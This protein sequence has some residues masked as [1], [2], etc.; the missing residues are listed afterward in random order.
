VNLEQVAVIHGGADD[1]LHVVRLAALLRHQPVELR[2]FSIRDV[3]AGLEGRIL[4]VVERQEA[5]QLA[6]LGDARAVVG[7]GE[8]RDPALRRV[9]ARAAE[10]LLGDLFVR[11]RPDHVRA[12]DEHVA[13]LLHHEDEVGD[14]RRVHR[15]TGA[16][17]H[18]AAD[19]R[20]HAA[21]Q[22]V[23]QEDVRVA[24]QRFDAF[25]DA[26]AARVVQA[27][28]RCAHL[29]RQVHDLADLGSVGRAQRS[30]EHREVLSEDED[31]PPVHGAVAR[32]D[33]VAEHL[34]LLHAEVG[35][36]MGDEAIDLDEAARVEQQVEP[37]ARGELAG[38]VLLLD[39]N[40]AAALEGLGVERL[41]LRDGI[42]F[43]RRHGASGLARAGP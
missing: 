29:D 34:L 23:A 12:R 7:S 37:L 11:H 1:R 6:H 30:A 36:A 3:R 32:H 35:T 13:R 25:L 20:D 38:R 4:G 10:L 5:E 42:Q 21:G 43:G 41:E 18:D 15:A 9:R 24:R 26:R 17:T 2:H 40:F 28:D 31:A 22:R 33:A 8:V 39:T 16:R 14:G 27:H 19:L